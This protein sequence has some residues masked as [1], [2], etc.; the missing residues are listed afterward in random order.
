[1]EPVR[2][3]SPA[4]ASRLVARGFTAIELL[5]VIGVLGVL[6]ALALPSF[7]SLFERFRVRQAVEG[8][9]STL[10]YAR[11]EAIKRGGNV[12]VQ[13]LP[14]TPSS[15]CTLASLTGEWGCGWVVCTTTSPTNAN[16][17]TGSGALVAG[18]T[19][20]Q[21][22]DSLTNVEINTTAGN[23][24]KFNRWGLPSTWLGFNFVAKGKNFLSDPSARVVCMSSA[25][26]VR[27]GS[28][29]DV[30]NTSSP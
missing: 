15:N 18:A 29:E 10:Y 27:I 9:Q 30:C 20:L 26:R 4:C 22:F 8:L 12:T 2:N 24:V 28:A 14:S 19:A 5:V 17:V 3:L 1:M 7:Q 6:F 16:C 25:G 21:R 23:A 11:S 13:R